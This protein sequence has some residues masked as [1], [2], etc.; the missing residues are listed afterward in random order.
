MEHFLRIYLPLY[1]PG[2]LALAFVLPTYKTRKQTGINPITFGSADNAHNYIGFIMKFLIFLLFVTVVCFSS[3]RNWYKYLVPIDYLQIRG[4]IT[5]GLVLIHLSLIWIAIA[6]YQM[7]TSWRIGIDEDHTT[8]LRTK[9]IFS[10]SRNPV[11]L[12][13]MVSVFGIFLILPNALT[14]FITMMTY[15]IIQV[16][17]RL[18]EDFLARQHGEKY[19]AYKR[20][21]KRLI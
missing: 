15:F 9:G 8:E 19:E 17:I 5:A 16:Q 14:F 20:A 10:I 21:T 7:G 2:Y 12:G 3:G 4:L 11:F 6:Q 1:L 13:M 18:E